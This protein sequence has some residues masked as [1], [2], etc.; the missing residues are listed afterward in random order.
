MTI[1]QAL[2][3]LM[4]KK[5]LT[6]EQE[7]LKLSLINLKVEH[8]GRAKIENIKKVKAIIDGEERDS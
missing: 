4:S 6:F 1:N 5:N 7:D 8:G 3:Q 2:D